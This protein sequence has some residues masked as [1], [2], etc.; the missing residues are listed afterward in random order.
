MKPATTNLLQ[1]T[2]HERNTTPMLKFPYCKTIFRRLLAAA[3]VAL[4]LCVPPS[5][6]AACNVHGVLFKEIKLT[7]P[8]YLGV[9]CS[10]TFKVTVESEAVLGD[11][12]TVWVSIKKQEGSDGDVEGLPV[13]NV[14]VVIA[15]ESKVGSATF[16]LTGKTHTSTI[17][18]N[19]TLVA[20]LVDG[21]H[22]PED[23][24]EDGANDCVDKHEVIVYDVNLNV[25]RTLL[26]LKHDNKCN[27]EV[28]VLPADLPVQAYRIDIKRR[29]EGDESWLVLK[30]GKEWKPWRVV[31]AGKFHLRG[32]AKINEDTECYSENIDID[33]RFPS[34]SQIEGDATVRGATDQLWEQTKNDC[35]EDPNRRREWGFWIRL[36][37]L[38]DVYT[39]SENVVGTWAHPGDEANIGLGTH[40]PA[41]NPNPPANRRSGAVY[42]VASFHTHTP[43]TYRPGESSREVGPS[44]RDKDFDTKQEVPGIVY[45]YIHTHIIFDGTKH[46]AYIPFGHPK[47]APARR[48]FSEGHYRRPTPE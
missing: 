47:D 31:I 34:Y 21:E 48:Y 13:E 45:D 43:T 36:N 38:R 1:P 10:G 7:G 41:E 11:G 40:R 14:P 37:T 5:V 18:K 16:S 9:G 15:P 35:T 25:S 29:S 3:V 6:E 12:A 26:T 30:E 32:W 44:D 23:G 22:K 46:R 39:R 42:T 19:V 27:L 28:I 24:E 2:S 17:K 20:T 4:A 8:E 33:V